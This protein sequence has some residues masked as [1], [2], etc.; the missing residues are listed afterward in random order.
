MEVQARCLAHRMGFCPLSAGRKA[1]KKRKMWQW[2]KC[3]HDSVLYGVTKELTSHGC[4][5][6]GR[7]RTGTCWA[8]RLPVLLITGKLRGLQ[9]SL[10]IETGQLRNHYDS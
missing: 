6:A 2:F 9:G 10:L 3:H 5:K 7:L 1:L 4:G 8:D